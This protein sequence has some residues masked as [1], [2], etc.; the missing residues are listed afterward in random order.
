MNEAN[1]VG[2]K[3]QTAARRKLDL[4]RWATVTTLAMAMGTL[5]I[6]MSASASPVR[7]TK[8]KAPAKVKAGSV[9]TFQPTGGVCQSDTFAT[10]H[11]FSSASTDGTGDAGTYKGTKKLTMTWTAG[12]AAGE[13]YKAVWKKTTGDYTGTYAADGQSVT[14]T[15]D[16]AAAGGC[17]VAKTTPAVTTTPAHA[18]VQVT[19]QNTD[20]ATVTGT[21]GLTP[22]GSVHFYECAGATDT[23]TTSAAA[24]G[25]SD[26][27]SV[28]LSGSGGTASA[29]SAAFASSSPGGYCFL[30]VYSG[31]SNY[32]SGSDGSTTDECVTVTPSTSEL[33]TAPSSPSI[34]QG[35]METDTAT[36]TGD[37]GVTPT[38]KI[39]FYVCGPTPTATACTDANDSVLGSPVALSGSG[40]VA[41][42]TSASFSTST[43]GY[44][45]FLGVYPGNGHYAPASD[46][47]T[48]DE[49]FDVIPFT[50]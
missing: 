50:E 39:T 21:D 31:D 9:W 2:P 27:G 42:A 33:T 35:G 3:G 25:G 5:V 23:C 46:G 22:T 29:T 11:K 13:V 37:G 30:G 34:S 24:N 38:G 12:S 4:R 49:C 43:T 36:V 32:T 6:G 45:C 20:T 17:P 19:V 47:S 14:A 26:L 18:T 16:P 41:T 48:T 15:L 8:S 10:H 40:N 1:A 28:P 7:A 44:Y